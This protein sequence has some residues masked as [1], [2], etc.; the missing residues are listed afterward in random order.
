[1][2]SFQYLLILLKLPVLAKGN[3][4]DS[5]LKFLLNN[6]NKDVRFL[7]EIEEV[8]YLLKLSKLCNN[9]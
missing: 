1:M 7:F 5:E 8:Y 9:F 6:K 3:P 2:I 4:I